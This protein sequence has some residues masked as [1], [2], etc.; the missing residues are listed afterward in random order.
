MFVYT[1]VAG[2]QGQVEAMVGQLSSPTAGQ[3]PP[4][5]VPAPEADSEFQSEV[6]EAGAAT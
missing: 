3:E 6:S 4:G 2:D 1:S 5:D